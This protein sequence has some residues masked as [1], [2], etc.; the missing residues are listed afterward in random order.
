MRDMQ[1]DLHVEIWLRWGAVG[2]CQAVVWAEA[3]AQQ[4]CMYMWGDIFGW[5]GG[6]VHIGTEQRLRLKNQEYSLY[7]F[8]SISFILLLSLVFC[9]WFVYWSRVDLQCCVSFRYTAKWFSYTY[10]HNF[11]QILFP[12]GLLQNIGYS[13]SWQTEQLGFYPEGNRA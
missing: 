5:N 2:M 9:C 10:I 6:K 7:F 12:Y 13:L 4:I 1:L 3:K 11:F 8:L